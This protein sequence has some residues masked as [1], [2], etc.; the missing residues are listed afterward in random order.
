MSPSLWAFCSACQSW[1]DLPPE[2]SA[3][4]PHHLRPIVTLHHTSSSSAYFARACAVPSPGLRVGGEAP[5]RTRPI[6]LCG[7]L[8]LCVPRFSPA[9]PLPPRPN[10]SVLCPWRHPSSKG[11]SS[12]RLVLPGHGRPWSLC[13]AFYGPPCQL[14]V[15]C[16]TVLSVSS[17]LQPPR[18]T[19]GASAAERSL[20]R[21]RWP[22]WGWRC[23]QVGRF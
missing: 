18:P 6:P 8:R 5:A 15:A 22:S 17:E 2:L 14:A 21:F 1:A 23:W 9:L 20:S 3:M 16:A 4:S 7:S 19:A 11:L 12:R 10:G 13:C